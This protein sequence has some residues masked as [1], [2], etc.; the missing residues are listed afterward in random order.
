MKS[1]PGP[2]RVDPMGRVLPNDG[3]RWIMEFGPTSNQGANAQL[4]AAAPELL[5]L[6]DWALDWVE[7]SH[8]ECD[9]TSD[10]ICTAEQY[11][12]G[13]AD[14]HEQIRDARAILAKAQ[15]E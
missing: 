8:Q 1:T 3:S 6:L 4:M 2:W 11:G 12:D 10:T 13:A 15:G 14:Q 7:K 5:E 9:L